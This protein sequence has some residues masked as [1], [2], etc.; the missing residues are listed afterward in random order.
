[1]KSTTLFARVKPFVIL[2]AIA[3]TTALVIPSGHVAAQ[4]TSASIMLEEITVTARRREENLQ[5]MPLSISAYTDEQMQVQGIYSID[6]ITPFVPNVVL[7][8][9]GRAN[10]NRIVIRGIGG[11]FPDPVE[12]FGSGMY[13]D[14]HY[15]PNSI[16]GYMST[17]DI[18]RIELLRGPQGTLFG[19]NVTGGAVNIIST[20]PGPDFDSSVLVRA[21]DDGQLDLRGMLNVPFSDT[22][23]GRFTVAREEFD[24]YYFNQNLGID[25]GA[26]ENTSGRAALRIQP[27]EEWLIDVSAYISRKRDDNNGGQCIGYGEKGDAPQWGGGAGNLERRLYTGA[28]ADF[29]ALCE[30]DMA[31]GDFVNSSDKYTFSDVDE[32]G[33]Q[34]GIDWNSAGAGGWDNIGVKAKAAYRTFDYV[35]FADRDYVSW[36][37]DGIG[38]AGAGT[39][40]ET[41]SFELLFEGK[42]MRISGSPWA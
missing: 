5:D 15:I 28:E 17:L 3:A 20:K 39:N 8:S 29:V 9:H 33:A 16:G 42:S 11:G 6:D 36:P 4:S 34:L 24:G 25:S 10:N 23:F 35:Y 41:Y 14:G 26:T 27:N 1:M 38:T 31:A 37:V 32:E 30:A 22:V 7:T 40:S 21:T 13:I 18:E 12:V 2:G 19:K